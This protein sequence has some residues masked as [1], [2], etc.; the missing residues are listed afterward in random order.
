[1]ST[2]CTTR[3]AN[4]IDDVAPLHVVDRGTDDAAVLGRELI[5]R[6]CAP[7]R[8]ELAHLRLARRVARSL[9]AVEVRD[10][11]V[12]AHPVLLL[13]VQLRGIG[14]AL[15][16]RLAHARGS[17]ACAAP[18]CGDRSSPRSRRTADSPRAR[19]TF[20]RRTRAGA[21]RTSM[22]KSI[23]SAVIVALSLTLFAL[24][25]DS[26][27]CERVILA[28]E[29]DHLAVQRELLLPSRHDLGRAA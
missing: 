19:A 27:R 12:A 15:R 16:V 4:A 14:H 25:F 21:A 26:T 2:V 10:D 5:E 11:R 18:A 22:R 24:P 23:V 9:R 6:L 1:M 8:D 7:L 29:V 28:E 3:F 20:P 17:R 13:R